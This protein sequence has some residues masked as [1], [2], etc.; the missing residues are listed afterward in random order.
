[1]QLV[2]VSGLSGSGKSVALSTLEDC[3][4]YCIDN[5]P[6][7]L[8]E[9][10]VRETGQN[11]GKTAI[12]IDCRNLTGD[13]NS[14]EEILTVLGQFAIPYRILFLIA[15]SDTLIKRYSETRRKHPLSHTQGLPLA[16]AIERERKL[17]EP[18]A[19]RA[20]L[21]LDTTHTNIHQLRES[22]LQRLGEDKR[23]LVLCFLSF[24]FKHGLPL[25]AD[26]VF[27]ARCL[28]NPHWEPALRPFT[29]RDPEVADY[30]QSLPET[31]M[32]LKQIEAFLNTWL[33]RFGAQNRS[34]LTIAIGCTGGRH[35][36]VYLAEKLGQRFAG[37]YSVIVRHRE[38]S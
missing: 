29:G 11:L 36:S 30:L 19:A 15:A 16:E 37:L 28:P 3:G 27:D 12:S 35:R 20:D 13:A 26:F 23:Q 21:I 6:V 14:F 24:G 18:I 2:I 9:A 17:L 4:Y 25:D 22:V 32:L 8:I 1:M 31:A 38:L 10:F 5:L 7:R 34:Y 33:P